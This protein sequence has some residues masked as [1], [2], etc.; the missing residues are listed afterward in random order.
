LPLG[1]R[2][3]VETENAHEDPRTIQE[4][5]PGNY[6]RVSA[7]DNGKGMPPEIR[8]RVME[9]FFTTKAD[10]ICTYSKTQA[11]VSCGPDR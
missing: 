6:V 7:S 8:D 9:P 1:G 3:I 11:A 10:P 5:P 4:V 2:I